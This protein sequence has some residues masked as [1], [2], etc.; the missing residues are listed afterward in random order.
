MERFQQMKTSTIAN[1]DTIDENEDE[2]EE[3]I[4][5]FSPDMTDAE[6]VRN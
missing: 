4:F 1:I 5:N 6:N 3:T 2:N